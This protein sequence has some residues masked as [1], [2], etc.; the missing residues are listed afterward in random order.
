MSFYEWLAKEVEFENECVK[1]EYGIRY[2]FCEE[3]IWDDFI[4]GANISEE[5]TD[6]DEVSVLR[7]LFEEWAKTAK[8]F[9]CTDK[10]INAR[11]KENAAD[12]RTQAME[13]GFHNYSSENGG[14]YYPSD[15]FPNYY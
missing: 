4:C 2:F 8:P 1:E 15:S 11:R 3:T 14:T 12:L 7:P 10:D 6:D 5:D 9:K 13:M